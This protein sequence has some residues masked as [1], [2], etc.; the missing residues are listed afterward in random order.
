[1][2][3]QNLPYILA[4][5]LTGAVLAVG[6]VGRAD[7]GYEAAPR[8]EEGN[9]LENDVAT[10]STGSSRI[11]VSASAFR[12]ATSIFNNTAYTLWI[13][14]SASSATV[15]AGFPILSSATFSLQSMP[16]EVHGIFDAAAGADGGNV[17]IIRGRVK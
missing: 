6:N 4:A 13:A 9:R 12:P 2:K 16:G 15:A 7:T 14:G 11:L 5:L 3:N 10:I 8:L 17:R 1:M